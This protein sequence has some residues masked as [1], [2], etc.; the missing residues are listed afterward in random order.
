MIT[1][2]PV[3]ELRE[4]ESYLKRQLTRVS[5]LSEIELSP[6]DSKALEAG[7]AARFSLSEPGTA[8]RQISRSLPVGLA[9]FLARL[10]TFRY[11]QGNYWPIVDEALGRDRLTQAVRSDFG[12]HFEQIVEGYELL[13]LPAAV[14]AH[15]YVSLILLH[16]SVPAACLANYFDQ[17]W[18]RASPGQGGHDVIEAAL[19][20]SARFHL[21]KP[22]VRFLQ[23]GG[24][25]AAD[26]VERTL[27]L[28]Q[29]SGDAWTGIDDAVAA[30][31]AREAGL[32]S[33]VGIAFRN[34]IGQQDALGVRKRALVAGR[35]W[36]RPE[37]AFDGATRS[38]VVLLPR[39]QVS[40]ADAQCVWTVEE[41]TARTF[42]APAWR[43]SG[44]ATTDEKRHAAVRPQQVYAVTW[45]SS[46]G[47]KR[48]KS[49]A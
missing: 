43:R 20:S 6:S 13:R 1:Q 7:I 34:W 4:L 17:V 15:R 49:T 9:V 42:E 5:T 40:S 24:N 12:K 32:G 8:F 45:R 27:D 44:G 19:A 10:G 18:A 33:H 46:E 31:R 16:G 2:P 35:T 36:K 39:Q 37:L 23:H 29:D 28:A 22:V 47:Q 38:P 48:W 11:A 26:W 30:E 21:N 41:E 14:S 3:S 25:V